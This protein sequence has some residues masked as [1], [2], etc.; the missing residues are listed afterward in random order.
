MT[1]NFPPLGDPPPPGLFHWPDQWRYLSRAFSLTYAGIQ[2]LNTTLETLIVTTQDLTTAVAAGAELTSEVKAL[3]AGLTDAVT[4]EIAEVGTLLQTIA[5]GPT[6]DP[7]VADAVTSVT[8]SNAD[9]TT[10]RDALQTLTTQA[11][12][13]DATDPNQ[14]PPA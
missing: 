4:K 12:A 11:Q 3:L 10:I 9:L 1:F 6:P 13:D 5:N 7:A 14:Q 8:A 2:A